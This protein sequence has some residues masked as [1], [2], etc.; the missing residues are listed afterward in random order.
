MR[1]RIRGIALIVALVA[2]PLGGPASAGGA[3]A[4]SY[5]VRLA[6]GAGSGPAARLLED[7]GARTTGS[8][9]ALHLVEVRIDGAGAAE[10]RRSPLVEWARPERTLELHGRAP[11]DPLFRHQ[12]PLHR[13]GAV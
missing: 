9:D 10:L 7:A 6:P 13:I 2:A 8:I 1:N 12:W 3:P 4:V 5:V 11:N